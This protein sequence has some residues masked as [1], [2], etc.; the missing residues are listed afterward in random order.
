M[1]ASPPPQGGQP[2]DAVAFPGR[3]GSRWHLPSLVVAGVVAGASCL[4]LLI[5]V[6]VI[7]ALRSRGYVLG[8]AYDAKLILLVVGLVAAGGLVAAL[9]IAL[10]ALRPV[11]RGTSGPGRR[12]TSLRTRSFFVIAIAVLIPSLCLAAFGVWAYYKSWQTAGVLYTGQASYRASELNTEIKSLAKT[13]MHLS[14][15]ERAGLSQAIVDQFSVNGHSAGALVG[16]L[17]P[18]TDLK[19]HVL[20]AWAARSVKQRG[21]AIGTWKGPSNPGRSDLSIVAWRTG[22]GKVYYYSDYWG[23]LQSFSPYAPLTRLARIGVLGLAL[24][25]VLGLLGAWIL[26]RSVVRPVRRLAEASGRLAEGEVDVSVK[27]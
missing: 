11:V 7:A 18:L 16:Q 9:V 23:D 10:L 19:N 20:P 14:A 17:G 15:A 24:I 25:V 12:A 4:L 22:A 2:G 13:P 5:A 21:Y 27:P 8:Y 6:S 1:S 3:A 26:S